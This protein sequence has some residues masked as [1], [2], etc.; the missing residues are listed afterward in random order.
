M[1][2]I[3][4][5]DEN[6]KID[7]NLNIPDIRFYNIEDQPFTIHGV[8][9]EGSVF[10]RMPEKAART[11]DDGVYCQSTNT[12]GGRVRYQTAKAAGDDRIYQIDSAA[13]MALAKDGGLVDNV[14]PNDFGF[15]SMSVAVEK[16]MKEIF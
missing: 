11:V 7:T 2:K 9:R 1:K 12:A 3:T 16:V 14:H 5:I 13:L 4:D 8:F 10:R 6:F 15:A